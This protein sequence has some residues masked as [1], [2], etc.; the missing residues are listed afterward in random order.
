MPSIV[1]GSHAEVACL[2]KC[3][4]AV[5]LLS[6][7]FASVACSVKATRALSLVNPYLPSMWHMCE[8]FASNA[9]TREW[10]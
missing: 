8:P 4:I 1:A 5:H 7:P 10:V 3:C 6:E 2:E 9:A